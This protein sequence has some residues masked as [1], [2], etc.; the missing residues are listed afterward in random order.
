MRKLDRK[1]LGTDAR[2]L[3]GHQPGRAPVLERRLP[4]LI[5]LQPII[6]I[7]K[8]KRRRLVSFGTKRG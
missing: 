1:D 4:T 8:P 6:C 3:G 5:I 7:A 2:N